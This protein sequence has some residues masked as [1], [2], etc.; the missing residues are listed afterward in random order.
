MR[1]LWLTRKGEDYVG[2]PSTR[3]G[4]EQAVAEITESMFAGE[5]WPLHMRHERFEATVERVMP[6]A[7]WII[8][9][10]NDLHTRKPQGLN[11]GHFISDLHGKHHYMIKTPEGHI[12]LLNRVGYRAI[13]MRYTEIHGVP[14][15]VNVYRSSL[16]PNGYWVPWSFDPDRF[17]QRTPY[18]WNDVTSIGNTKRDVYPLRGLIRNELKALSGGHR[19]FTAESP[20]GRTY[21]RLI[22]DNLAGD[23]YAEVLG[24][25][26]IFIFDCSKYRY[27]LQKF[28]EGLGS[29]CLVMA[30]EPGGAKAL[31]LVDGRT[32]VKIDE[33]NWRHKLHYY[34]KN[35]DEADTIA[36]RGLAM[37]LKYHVH[38]VRAKQ[39]VVYLER[40]LDGRAPPDVRN[41]E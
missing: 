41:E 23:S 4:F 20:R 29:G 37:A 26:R 17:Y 13:F 30:T 8:D 6:D 21:E 38:D 19:V 16:K 2:A 32:Y 28:F 11:V 5:G 14:S 40:E 1:I 33:S 34:L 7:D 35:P 25:S 27:P 15:P 24:S 31:G 9:R 10:D 22:K 3:H 39:F 18:R 36:E 12:D